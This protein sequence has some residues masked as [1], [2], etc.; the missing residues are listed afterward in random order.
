MSH[1]VGRQLGKWYRDANMR[2]GLLFSD[3]LLYRDN[4][5]LKEGGDVSSGVSSGELQN[6]DDSSLGMQPTP[7]FLAGHT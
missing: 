5:G 1:G 4:A 7:V 3:S 6:D 2:R